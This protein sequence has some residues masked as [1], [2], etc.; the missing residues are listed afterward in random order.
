MHPGSERNRIKEV[1]PV[2]NYQKQSSRNKRV[3]IFELAEEK[4]TRI[5][6]ATS[7]PTRTFSALNLVLEIFDNS[8]MQNFLFFLIGAL[9]SVTLTPTACRPVDCDKHDHSETAEDGM[10]IHGFPSLFLV[11]L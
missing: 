4:K 11:C 5:T 3:C 9:V 1:G 10:F 6:K 7:L 8:N 2:I